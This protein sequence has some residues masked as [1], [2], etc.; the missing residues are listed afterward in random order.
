MF[1]CAATCLKKKKKSYRHAHNASVSV[2]W[3][4]STY[5]HNIN[6]G[7]LEV[8]QSYS[9]N[10]VYRA[11]SP[12]FSLVGSSIEKHVKSDLFSALS[13][14]D[15]WQSAFTVEGLNTDGNKRITNLKLRR[16]TVCVCVCVCGKAQSNY[17]HTSSVQ[18]QPF[19][20]TRPQTCVWWTSK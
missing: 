15:S 6:T 3:G 5:T 19:H 14:T 10:A 8:L 13:T 1:V 12:P 20:R 2:F 7:D 18:H 9:N 11:F 4:R 17:R 16:G